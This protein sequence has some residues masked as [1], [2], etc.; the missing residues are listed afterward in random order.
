MARVRAATVAM[1]SSG[2]MIVA[3]QVSEQ[4][5]DWCDVGL[6]DDGCWY[7]NA[8]NPKTSQDQQSP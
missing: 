8:T 7:D 6:T 5:I 1:R 2:Q 4:A 3:N